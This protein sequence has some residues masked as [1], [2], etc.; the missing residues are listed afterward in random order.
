M[1]GDKKCP[2]N[3]KL[4]WRKGA[5]KQGL[6]CRHTIIK[7][8]QQV[9][10][11]FWNSLSCRCAAISTCE[12]ISTAIFKFTAILPDSWWQIPSA[13]SPQPSSLPPVPPP[14]PPAVHTLPAAPSARPFSL[15]RSPPRPRWRRKGWG[16]KVWGRRERWRRWR[17]RFER[18]SERCSVPRCCLGHSAL[19]CWGI[20]WQ[21]K[22]TTNLFCFSTFS[23][24]QRRQPLY[25]VSA[26]SQWY[27]V[28]VR[29]ICYLTEKSVTIQSSA[30]FV[31][32]SKPYFPH[33]TDTADFSWGNNPIFSE[34]N[35]FTATI[36]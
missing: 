17:S 26:L 31:K 29:S 19:C 21:H 34:E 27:L 2:F 11:L 4:W 24:M 25:F 7:L 6:E 3:D 35:F 36:E 33:D 10:A 15:S 30:V 20:S 18:C 8:A 1:H 13:L 9:Y 28:I 16:W 14:S 12:W 23:G 22:W 32:S 5:R